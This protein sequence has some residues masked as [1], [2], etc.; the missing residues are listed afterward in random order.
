[1]LDPRPCQNSSL[2]GLFNHKPQWN[3][4]VLGRTQRPGLSHFLNHDH[5]L[6]FQGDSR[7]APCSTYTKPLECLPHLRTIFTF[8]CMCSAA[9]INYWLSHHSVNFNMHSL[10]SRFLARLGMRWIYVYLTSSIDIPYAALRG[11]LWNLSDLFFYT[12]HH[13]VFVFYYWHSVPTFTL[14]LLKSLKYMGNR[15]RTNITMRRS[16]KYIYIRH[17]IIQYVP[18]SGQRSW[19]GS[20]HCQQSNNKRL[21]H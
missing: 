14:V 12:W 3:F 16:R 11:V 8:C 6:S 18:F 9:V 10:P 17:F 5:S 13:F 4:V 15:T 21:K 2:H 1:M 7:N 20:K 19:L